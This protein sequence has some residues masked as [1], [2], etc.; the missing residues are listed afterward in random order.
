MSF[1]NRLT[2]RWRGWREAL[3]RRLI[4]WLRARVI[5]VTGE[6]RDLDDRPARP[7][8]LVAIWG[9]EHYTETAV[10]HPIAKW[11]D[12][13][14][15]AR[16]YRRGRRPLMFHIGPFLD[17]KRR[18]SFFELTETAVDLPARALF[19]VP[20]SLLLSLTCPQDRIFT[21]ER[22]GSRYFLNSTNTQLAGGLIDSPEKFALAHGM[23]SG[24]QELH[25]EE[26]AVREQIMVGLPRVPVGAWVL[27]IG[28]LAREVSRK[29]A[30]P[31]GVGIVALWLS[32]LLLSQL[33]LTVTFELRQHSLNQLGDDVSSLLESQRRLDS[34]VAEQ[35]D[36]LEVAQK[37]RSAIPV[38]EGFNAVWQSGG[39]VRSAKWVDGKA[40]LN[41]AASDATAVLATISQADLIS[42]PEF[43]AAVRQNNALQEFTINFETKALPSGVST[44]GSR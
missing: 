28:P 25:L 23:R 21:V 24:W 5:W 20:E 3:S 6:I 11:S 9:R 33:Y 36:Y 35:D 27:A 44:A 39:L 26:G 17:G 29:V 34:L 19:W 38:W 7:W 41:G 8:S 16:L 37:R 22:G 4:A 2:E 32:F 1:S 12:A 10:D 30:A 42:K 18:M 31:L 15:V 43:G 14:S 40:G 13:V